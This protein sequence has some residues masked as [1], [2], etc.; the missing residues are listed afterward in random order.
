MLGY[1]SAGTAT[2]ATAATS[3]GAA[4]PPIGAW[5]PEPCSRAGELL[6]VV[7]VRIRDVNVPARVGRHAGG[8][9]EVCLAGALTPPGGE[10][11]GGRVEFLDATRG[12]MRDVSLDDS[13]GV[14]SDG[15]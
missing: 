4:Q 5:R 12:R 3:G 14:H 10:D 13:V 11:G 8:G 2:S 7:V 15:G 6:D 1:L 9:V